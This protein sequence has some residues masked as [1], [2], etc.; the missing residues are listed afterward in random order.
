MSIR[1]VFMFGGQ[2]SQY[3]GMGRELFSAHPVFE[4]SMRALD[5]MFGDFGIPGLLHEVYPPDGGERMSFD[6]LRHTHP[7]IAMI[8][9]ALFDALAADGVEPDYLIGYSLG[10][11][12][13]ATVAGVLDRERLVAA[14]AEQVRL[15]EKNCSPGA[16]SA[17][18]GAV[19]ELYDPAER[20]WEGV[21]LAAVNHDRH[22]VVSGAPETIGRTE[23]R[24]RA[25]GITCVRLPVRYAFHSPA[26][27]AVAEP[28]LR[29]L[30]GIPLCQPR[31][32]LLSS[33]L[34]AEVT[35]PAPETL[36]RMFRGRIGFRDTVRLLEAQHDDLR[37]IDLTPSGTLARF[38][39]EN[40]RSGSGAQA[41]P[42]LDRFAPAGQ[43]LARARALRATARTRPG[44]APRPDSPHT[45]VVFPGQ[46]SHMLGMAED[47]FGEFP[48]LVAQAD[49]VLGYSV[50][51]LCVEDPDGVLGRTEFTQP[52]LF[53]ANALY[54]RAW[55]REHGPAHVFAGHSLG[56]YNALWAA[57]A[58][59][60][61]T[62]VRLVRERGA[63]MSAIAGGGMA[64]VV[65]LNESRVRAALSANGFDDLDIA[66]IN[67][68]D[69]LVISGPSTS[70]ARARETFLETGAR[71]VP[72]RVGGA[73]HS[74]YMRSARVEFER[75]L[76]GVE[77]RSPRVPVVANATARPYPDGD[78]RALL[79]EQ[80]TG[81]VRWDET[82]RH[83]LAQGVTT[84]REVGPG[85]V[86]TKLVTAIRATEPA[87]DPAAGAVPPRPS[88]SPRSTATAVAI[89]GIGCRMPGARDHREFLA[90]LRDRVDSVGE[91]PADR[92]QADLF[93]DRD[94]TAPN[95]SV[96]KWLAA[97]DDPWSFDHEYFGVSPREATLLDPL[98]RL[99]ME[100]T[101]HCLDDAG[102]T[103]A[104][105]AAAR[106]AVYIGNFERDHLI[107]M[108]HPDRDVETHS[109]L[110]VYDCLL[111]NRLSQT[112]DL[113]GASVSV[114]A[115][116]ASSLVA[117]HLG[118]QALT[119]GEADYVLAGGVNLSTRPWK[120]VGFSKA[121]MLSPDGR[122]KTFDRDANGFVPGDGVGVVLLRRYEDAV[123][124]GDHIYGLVTGTAVNHG[125]RRT[126]ITAPTVAS[127]RA[128]IAT[129]IE[130]AG[131]SPRD[132]TYVEAHGTGT[133]LGDPIEVEALRQVFAPASADTRWCALGSVKSN[134]GHLEGAAGIAGL[135]KVLMMMRARRIVPTLHV[136]TVNPLI[137]VE[138]GPFRL[139]LDEAEWR[140]TAPGEPLRAGVSSFG[141]G[142]VNSHVIV[143]EYLPDPPPKTTGDDTESATALT[144]SSPQGA[145]R[146]PYLLSAA[147]A[148]SLRRLVTSWQAALSPVGWLDASVGDICATLATGRSPLPFR[149]A[150]FAAD[151]AD[152]AEL[153]ATAQVPEHAPEARRW[154]VRV[155]TLPM[156]SP[157]EVELLLT[158]PPFREVVDEY[159]S[160]VR[161][162]L[163]HPDG[164]VARSV[165]TTIVVSALR[166]LGLRAELIAGSGP[167][168]W[169]TLAAAGCLDI[170]VAAELAAGQR[171]Q[172]ELRPPELA[173]AMPGSGRIIQPLSIDRHYLD[174]LRAAGAPDPQRFTELLAF[175]ERL[176]GQRSI[177]HTLRDWQGRLAAR[178]LGHWRVDEVTPTDAPDEP[179]RA[180]VTGI[181]VQ[182]ALDRLDRKWDLPLHRFLDGEPITEMLN[183]LLD[184]V[185][186]AEDLLGLVLDG[187][188][189]LEATAAV[190]HRNRHR[191]T[192]ADRDR[193]PML[194]RAS[195][196]PVELRDV[197]TWVRLAG[198]GQSAAIAPELSVVSVAGG[199]ATVLVEAVSADDPLTTP[200]VELWRR[201]VE[202]RWDKHPV[203]TAGKR[204][205]LPTT[206]F[207]RVEHRRTGAA[208]EATPTVPDEAR[209]IE[210]RPEW[211]VTDRIP[212][213]DSGSVLVVTSGDRAEAIRTACD[214]AYATVEFGDRFDRIGDR[215]WTVP[216]TDIEAWHRVFDAVAESDAPVRTVVLTVAGI[217]AATTALQLIKAAYGRGI[218]ILALGRHVGGAIAPELAA[219][220][221]MGRCLHRETD[222]VTLRV[223]AVPEGPADRSTWEIVAA[224]LGRADGGDL[225][226]HHHGRRE[227]RVVVPSITDLPPATESPGAGTYVVTGG[228][229][230]IGRLLAAHL[231]TRPGVRVALV[232]RAP[233]RPDL[234]DF[235]PAATDRIAYFQADIADLEAT[236]AVAAR[237]RD[238]FGPLRG[239]LHCAGTLRDGYLAHKSIDDLTAV[240]A[241]KVRGAHNLD[242]ATRDDPLDLFALFSSVV[243]VIGNP[244]Q[245][246]Y[247]TANAYLDEFAIQREALREKG[248]RNGRSISIG[249][250]IWRD[251]GMTVTEH[252]ILGTASGLRPM[253]ADTGLALWDRIRATRTGSCSFLYG[254][255]ATAVHLLPSIDRTAVR[256]AE[257]LDSAPE[258]GPSTES[259]AALARD[260]VATLIA[261]LRGVPPESIDLDLGLDR[262][263]LDSIV[264]SE[265]N[266]RIE[267]D[268]G[269][270]S[271]TLLFESRT[272]DAAAT[273]IAATR[274]AEL[275]AHYGQASNPP[276]AVE[277]RRIDATPSVASR[278]IEPENRD[279]AIVGLAGRYPMADD[280]GAF[281]ENLGAG[282]DC[283]REVPQDRPHGGDGPAAGD[284]RWGGFLDGVDAFDPLFFNISPR[285]AE[286]MDPQER[287]L[288]QTA[289]HALEDAGYPPR[290]L[291]DPDLPGGR[292]VGVF[293]G[294]TTQTYHLWGPEQRRAGTGVIPLSTQWSIANRLSYRLNL[295]GPSMPVDTACAA[296]LTA[297][298]LA[299]HSLLRGE[300]AMALVGAVNL[301]LHPAKYEWLAQLNMLS[302]TGRCHAFGA[303]ADG[304]VPGEGVGAAVLKP[305][306][307]AVADGDRIL[308]VIKG[309]AVNHGGRTSGFTVP[310]PRAQARLITD[311]LA[312]AGLAPAAIGYIEA[313]GTGTELGDP[314][315]IAGLTEAFG[316]VPPGSC[317]IGSVKSAIGH[318][319]SASG[320][321]GLTKVLLQMK[322]GRIVP[323]LHSAE[324]NPRIDF[325]ATPFTVAHDLRPW[326]RR[327]DGGVELPRRAGISSFGA[328]GS[329]A[330]VVV[331]E[332]PASTVARGPA[333]GSHLVVVS[334]SDADRLRAH[335]ANLAREIRGRAGDL[336]VS[337]IAHQLQVRREPLAERLALIADDP[338]ELADR[339]TEF[340]EDR[341]STGRNWTT[342]RDL[343][344]RE[345]AVRDLP[346]AVARRD[347]PALAA[348]WVT[349]AEV[350][351]E[352]LYPAPL[353]HVDLPGY[354]FAAERYWVPIISSAEHPFLT[355]RHDDGASVEFTGREPFL[356]HHRVD[357]VPIFPAA[358]YIEMV[359][360]AATSSG[361]VPVR[362][363]NNVWAAPI[364]VPDARTVRVAL[365]E[366][367]GHTEYTVVGTAPDGTPT[368]HATGRI[369]DLPDG[370]RPDP[371]DLAAIRA[372][373]LGEIDAVEFYS[374]IHRRGLHL[375]PT[376]Q[377]ITRVRWNGDEAIAEIHRP[378]AGDHAAY[379]LHPGMFDAA[380]QSSLWLVAQRSRDLHL[381]F[382][383][384][385]VDIFGPLPARAV[386]HVVVRKSTVTG[387][388]ID[389]R[390][391]DE[392]GRVVLRV[393]DMWLRPWPRGGSD[394]TGTYF[395]P[396]WVPSAAADR[397]E[398]GDVLVLAPTSTAAE[399]IADELNRQA[400]GP[401]RTVLATVGTSF[402]A[403]GAD[404][405]RVRPDSDVDL[406]TLCAAGPFDTVIV[407]CSGGGHTPPTAERVTEQIDADVLPV[408]LLLRALVRATGKRRIRVVC[409]YSGDS[410]AHAALGGLLRTAGRE[411]ARLSTVLVA[412]P[413]EGSD[414]TN[415]IV[416]EA[417]SVTTELEVRYRDGIRTVLRWRRT[418]HTAESASRL[419]HHGVYLI[420]GG[421]GG[422]GVLV[423]RWLAEKC[424]ARVVLAGRSAPGERFDAVAAAV[425]SAGG[426]VSYV[427]ADLSTAV[428]ARTAVEA[429]VAEYGGLHGVFHC[430]GV[431]GD[432][433]LV[434]QSAARL[435]AV[436]AGKVL[437]A[438]HLDAATADRRLD[439]LCLF[440]STAAALGSAGQAP[441]SYANGFLD[442]YAAWREARGQRT[443]SID[444]PLWAEGG[445]GVDAAVAEWLRTGLG[446][447]PLPTALGLS[448]L[449]TALDSSWTQVMF[450]P[451]DGDAVGRHLGTA[452]PPE[453]EPTPQAGQ[454]VSMSANAS[455]ITGAVRDLL[456]T[457]IADIGKLAADRIRADRPIGDYG[458]DSLSLGTLA[459]RLVK[460]L[461]VDITAA[462][463]F[464]YTT[465]DEIAAHLVDTFPAEL[466][467]TLSVTPAQAVST[468]RT[469]PGAPVVSQR[470]VPDGPEPIAII[471]MH[472]I[473]PGSP[474]LEAFWRN[475][476]DGRDL[477]T[478]I[479][480]DRWDWRTNYHTIPGPG[481]TNSKWG[482]FLPEVDRFD[483]A[484]FGISPREARLMDPQQR[485]FLQTA[486]R[487]VEE[488][489][490]RPSDLSGGRTG[491]FVG[492][493]SHDYYDLLR[494]AGVPIE[495]HTTTGLFHAILANRVSYLLD[496]TGPSFPIDT[497]C[498]SSLVA[499]RT[500]IESLR[501]G[502]CDT[503]LVGGVNLLLSPMVYLSFARAGMLS[504]TGRCRTFDTAAD[505]YVR[506]EGVGALLLKP[507]S[508]AERDGDHIHAI[509][510]GSAVNHGGK[511]STLTTPNPV[512]QADLITRA[513]TEGEVDPATVGYLELH[514]T[515]TALGDPIEINGVR[516]A[517]R[518]LRDRAGLPRLTE[519]TTLIGSVKSNMG[520]AEAAAGMAGIFKVV[521]AMKHGRIPG[522]LHISEINPH[523]EL[524]D[525]PFAIVR[526]TTAWPRMRDADG[527]ELPRRA[528]ISSFGFG[529]VNAHV[530]LEEYIP[531]PQP[532]TMPT[533]QI[534]V[535]SARS[536]E[537]LREH[538]RAVAD[539]CESA[540]AP[541]DIAYTLQ[542]GR[543]PLPHRLALVTASATELAAGLRHF[544]AT[545]A[546]GTDTWY[547]VADDRPDTVEGGDLRE[548]A[549][550]WVGGAAVDWPA[551]HTGS[552]PRR[553]SLP[554]YPFARERHW[555]PQPETEP[556]APAQPVAARRLV[557]GT[558]FTDDDEG[559]V[560]R[561]RLAT[562]DRLVDEHRVHGAAVVAGVVQLELAAAALALPRPRRVTELRW[563]RPLE[564]PE[565]G[566]EVT[567]RLTQDGG[568][569]VHEIRTERDGE[570][571]LHS[572]GRW[573]T[574]HGA[575]DVARPD[576]DAV[577]RRC[578]EEIDRLRIYRI[579]D[580]IEIEYGRLYRGL[581]T[582]WIGEGE[583]LARY[584]AD[585]GSDDRSYVFPPTV[586]D[587]ALQAITVLEA[588]GEAI[589][590]TRLPFSVESVELIA[591]PPATGYVHVL[592]G[593]DGHDI[594]VL[595][596]AGRPC[597]VLRQVVVRP[598]RD[599]L[600]GVFFRPYWTAASPS[601]TAA[602]P[603]GGWL[604]VGPPDA[605]G[606]DA[607]LTAR[608]TG[609]VWRVRTGRAN[610]R[611]AER[612]W[613]ID[614]T[615]PAEGLRDCLRE[616]GTVRH[617]W[618]LGGLLVDE[619][620]PDDPAVLGAG[621]ALLFRLVRALTET[622][623]IQHVESIR[624][625]VNDAHDVAG[626]RV[627]NP[628]AA[629]LAGLTKS[630][631]H[632]FP[633]IGVN[634]VDI[635]VPVGYRPTGAEL[636]RVVEA[637][638]DEPVRQD[639]REVALV[640]G[641][642]MV[643]VLRPVALGPAPRSAFRHG[644]NYMIIG[645]AGG[646]GLALAE[647]LAA[648]RSARLI[649]IGRSPRDR[650]IEAALERI[651][652]LGGQAAYRQA[653]V[654]NR[655]DMAAAI[656][657]AKTFGPLHGVVHAAMVLHDGI[658]ERL[659]DNAFDGVLD[660]KARGTAV[661]ADLLA[662]EPLDFLLVMSSLQTFTGAA[663]QANYAAASAAQ[664]AVAHRLATRC[665]F[666]VR[667]VN[668]GP[669]AEV[670]RVAAPDYQND[671]IAR[672]YRPLRP[673]EAIAA[674]ERILGGA[675]RQLAVLRA[676]REVLDSI[677]VVRSGAVTAARTDAT[678]DGDPAEQAA[679][680]EFVVAELRRTFAGLGI[681]TRPEEHY[682]RTSL[683]RRLGALPKYRGLIDA[684]IGIL[685]RHGVLV[686]QADL[687]VTTDAAAHRPPPEPE[688]LRARFPRLGDR[689][690][691]VSVCLAALPDVLTGARS[692]TEVLFPN[693]S[694][695]QVATLYRG[696]PQADYCNAIVAGLIADTAAAGPLRVLE[697]GAGTGATTERILDA[698]AA[699]HVEAEYDVTDVSAA[700]VR[701]AAATLAA[702]GDTARFRTLDIE[703]PALEQGFAPA[704][705]DI[706]VAANV[707]HATADLDTALGEIRRL[708]APGGRLVLT[709]VTAVQ[710]FH[711]ITFG[712]L[713]GWWRHSDTDRRLPDSPLLDTHMWRSRLED[714]G[715]ADVRVLGSGA[716]PGVLRQHVLVATVGN[717][718][719][720]DGVGLGAREVPAKS[721]PGTKMTS[722]P[723][724]RGETASA[725]RGGNA[726]DPRGGSTSGSGGGSAPGSRGRSTP[727]SGGGSTPKPGG[728]STPE[729]E[730]GNAPEPGDG[731]TP[732]S[733]SGST[734]EPG[735]GGTPGSGTGSTPE[736][737]SEST[738]GSVGKS[739]PES[740][741][742]SVPV[743]GSESTPGFRGRSAPGFGT[744]S[745]L[746]SGSGS[747]PGAGRGGASGRRGGSVG[748]AGEVGGLREGG[749][750]VGGGV[751]V[752]GERVGVRVRA[753]VTELVAACLGVRAAEVGQGTPLAELGVDSIVAVELTNRLSEALGVGLKTIVVFDHPT[754]AD[755]SA[756]IVARYG[757]RLGALVDDEPGETAVDEIPLSPTPFR[758]VRFDRPGHPRDL[759][760]VPF[761]PVAPGPGQVEV[762]VRA[763]PINF[764][765]FLFAQ[766]LYPTMP[767][768]PCTPGVEVSGVVRRVG[769]GVQRFSVGD[770]VIALTGPEFGGQ[771]S[772]VVTDEDFVVAK[773][774]NVS[775]EQACGFPVAFL[776]MYLAFERAGVRP[777]DK[778]LIP[779]A[780][781]TNGLVAVQLARLAGARV[782][783]TAGGQHKIDY[784]TRM[785]VP[786]AIDHSRADVV[787][788]VLRRT[789]GVG[790]DVVIN[791]RGGSATQEGLRV[792]AP[793]GRYVE[794]AVFGLQSSGGLDLS[795]LVDNQSFHSFNTKKFFRRHPEL[796]ARYLHTAAEYLASGEVV[797]A[798]AHVVPFDRIAEAYALKEDRALIGRVV[799][800]MPDPHTESAALAAEEPRTPGEIPVRDTDIAVIG[801]SGRFPGAPDV[802]AFWDN[803]ASG[804]S[805]IREVP[806]ER[807]RSETY[808]DP[809]PRRLDTSNCKWGG[810]LDDV[811]RFDATFF[812]ISA[813]EAA[814]TDPQQ[815]LFLEE[816]W[817][818]VED[819]GYPTA[820][821]RG[822][823]CGVFV[824]V[825][826]SQYLS[827]MTAAG[828]PKPAQVFWGNESS[829]LAGRIAYL[830]DLKGPTMAVNTACSSSLVA[831][832]L[833]VQSLIRGEC[834]TAIAGGVFVTVDP[835]YYVVA[836]NGGM[837]AADGRCKTF[838]AAADGFVPG[839]AVAALVLKP[840]AAALRDGDRIHGVV[841]GSAV[842]QD[843]RTNGLTAPSGTAQTEVA[844]AAYAA[845][846]I[847]PATIGYVEAH[848]TGTGLGDAIEVEALTTAFRTRTDR[849][850][851]CAIGTAKTNVGHTAAASGMVGLIK[852]LLAMR[853]RQIPPSLNFDNPN[854]MIDFESS[855]FVVN[856][857]L[858][859]WVPQPG[860]PRRAAV[861]GFGFSGTNAHVLLE[862][863]PRPSLSAFEPMA[864]PVVVPISAHTPGALRARC[865]QLA[866]W[867]D[868]PGTQTPMADLA[869]HLQTRRDHFA[870]RAVFV[871]ADRTA[872]R[873]AL[874]H[875]DTASADAAVRNETAAAYLSGAEVTWANNWHGRSG[876][877]LTLPGYPFEPQ[878]HWFTN[879]DRV[880][881][882]VTADNQVVGPVPVTTPPSIPE[883]HNLFRGSGQPADESEVY[884]IAMTTAID[885]I[886]EVT[887]GQSC[888]LEPDTSHKDHGVDSVRAMQIATRINAEL[889][890]ALRPTDLFR[891]PTLRLLAA[892]IADL[893]GAVSVA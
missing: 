500:A 457:E 287:L 579:F 121:R 392:S 725:P 299:V 265:F 245:G 344:A 261:R 614:P 47:L 740:G 227:T 701:Q 830:L 659:S 243:A 793:E 611:T 236:V 887:G 102:V 238:R 356:D 315:E 552:H 682:T 310:N 361:G 601:A 18:L 126:T 237:I 620:A 747:T 169:P 539:H 670:G 750:V 610:R 76:N 61:G 403:T 343:A 868:G 861:S 498:S 15:V 58:F 680:D 440:S 806:G 479:P 735:T 661:L 109:V 622:D 289:W 587:A 702:A 437:G 357:G 162:L 122:C 338:I 534:F 619:T 878:R 771:A 798:V 12:V 885:A 753:V 776:A 842:N 567:I 194:W 67:S 710:P 99:L 804:T 425:R 520:H 365:A 446:L 721:T 412:L 715:F 872:L 33:A 640:G 101:Q 641:R 857:R 53:V 775:H 781:G 215:G 716:T 405:Y 77:L 588:A 741:I 564:V 339:L 240:L 336:R 321:A 427:Q 467:E 691:L 255:P 205:P 21:E 390:V 531:E 283:I 800:T 727:E 55:E 784:L 607:A 843:G 728:G 436:V 612:V 360:A 340:A 805:S 707:L 98:Q 44:P 631:A 379:V 468:P 666:P 589:T 319:E 484:F 718:E 430:A 463:F 770:E 159:G 257:I 855:P 184:G 420:S 413:R 149:I 170:T 8:Q 329:N 483:A 510:R 411:S 590:T 720:Q 209:L 424:G 634:C 452:E 826:P 652:Q 282:R 273:R 789:D 858:R 409:G 254:D 302:P 815:R 79:A 603:E 847:D 146:L 277:E 492:V 705:Y 417:L 316:D 375:G 501:A 395:R 128:V 442:A 224:E 797:P 292:A 249:W 810:F 48:D 817:R 40:L 613:E 139:A 353:P 667:I 605:W 306:R 41:I 799:V 56:E 732:G 653:D 831:L 625:V 824:G 472:G 131:I 298:H 69:Q 594:L 285:E 637:L 23:E 791:T 671:L 762:Q 763:F 822:S 545:G 757:D 331:E 153:L 665:G 68:A 363:R 251:G 833:A 218:S 210:L 291:G 505:G 228:L 235:G 112:F 814:Y 711:T 70:L 683:S 96:S 835:D 755:L 185:L 679:L 9:L 852:V 743:S 480:P 521:L 258:S 617:I 699:G 80:L 88:R 152:I 167:G 502:S 332:A 106:T 113:S 655:D 881:G 330:H 127:E 422:L 111:A 856:T 782:V 233:Q 221:G 624:S 886:T 189:G 104:T 335:C 786:D 63:L 118:V 325:A 406:E 414:E 423:A 348:A 187:D 11:S 263:G 644:G 580:A 693:G 443:I 632:E 223:L 161:A 81:P 3:Y 203:A 276:T 323:S 333:D 397:R 475:L 171:P 724:T 384:G 445:M 75:F 849:T 156:P 389:V 293:A 809:D 309:T 115:A 536:P 485:L 646:I 426:A 428:G 834:E 548:L 459:N 147:S 491:L 828:A 29:L 204:V 166:W 407:E 242:L 752:D 350:P 201:G 129:A 219:L 890:I 882:A 487:A 143:E 533:E 527:T 733:G 709:E 768:F 574:G 802:D 247:A 627:G 748:G 738:P 509:V 687:L 787:S 347:L 586:L 749:G 649:L 871:V 157:G 758:A 372:R 844:L 772:V 25:R 359:R 714:A 519:P 689:L 74:R 674:L 16:M 686:E 305:L 190:A 823:R 785:G 558:G 45:A 441:Y 638:L 575:A 24:L 93:Y 668:W 369:A 788:E 745:A 107:D 892:H 400:G 818:A 148:A 351:W 695:A 197:D 320:L 259:A 583:L 870:H 591:D 478:E 54:Y 657:K 418:P 182:Y 560:F 295:N 681:F 645:G 328:G 688:A 404:R 250:P 213:T 840:L 281:W 503:A 37:Y 568:D 599:V 708:L 592:R 719:M 504:P 367:A 694:M 394:D 675:E 458:F 456:V 2:G 60:F 744:G 769:P 97:L 853:H 685:V 304:F 827:R 373:C 314:I 615:D 525:S 6:T 62:G 474:D 544:A 447:H 569:I 5:T 370:D 706:V 577:R 193:Y 628:M 606:L 318:L 795:R 865:A 119:G 839:E 540:G 697:V 598:E 761:D 133:A 345:R 547:A 179:R 559:V 275:A 739:T 557:D 700:L 374:E 217:D 31:I 866:R 854:P 142:G 651:D 867:L 322:H 801:M 535:L 572:T 530:L 225:I 108:T 337:E 494:D 341:P 110:G 648:T 262:L 92:W 124:D 280:L 211:R 38:A 354:P 181:A 884:R 297:V 723:G 602:S 368:T 846:D 759:R 191:I 825:G 229:G 522:N 252:G 647:H 303:D 377:G 388:K 581:R 618:F 207:D 268:L 515:G 663:G 64:A 42:L 453:P 455:D 410:P 22:F 669:W 177:R 198:T 192:P 35:D 621:A 690:D 803:L 312:A 662:A 796:R 364:A 1:N 562:S 497:A 812:G 145:P 222:S 163:D 274:P 94:I 199:A 877:P 408:L 470:R 712:L 174:R 636:E 811:S 841:K 731:S 837:L 773:P 376:Y 863:P 553:V 730:G 231:L 448:A 692:A 72:L 105:L 532:R 454:E 780:T 415:H 464:E 432:D 46:G 114:D 342:V 434:R 34:V 883:A 704:H 551:L 85:N 460:R 383:I 639:G 816:A 566:R 516:R 469:A 584:T 290:R 95:R 294:V 86:L 794:I 103:A 571:I 385:S 482:G 511:V 529:G 421:A 696:E 891:F 51:K 850:G 435:R 756:Y 352:S 496:L 609:P 508:A 729:P 66:N 246:D 444:W 50:R 28:Y 507:L 449:G 726:P 650:R 346:D 465:V 717:V 140:P 366:V 600:D 766:G 537:Q 65:G 506:A 391:A 461:T 49:D 821:V 893:L 550:H 271:E 495:A 155:G 313:H 387:T 554:T 518:Q 230:R 642:R 82:V 402:E 308:G 150:G 358:G 673:A 774:D 206:E 214:D 52:A 175:A 736:S 91:I 433:Y 431:L 874:E 792:L 160:R 524:N 272:L 326:P 488:A 256:P 462:L 751:A 838:D 517:F 819:T 764:S 777:G 30:S 473:L 138:N 471:G 186:E 220:A 864:G 135:I 466:A 476:D 158:L 300:C 83:L 269:P 173:V 172:A 573:T 168:I 880:F 783:A 241:P 713:D 39:T 137:D 862:E 523:I 439:F 266:A 813:E 196:L 561:V 538:A 401:V 565:P 608:H 672:G 677:G 879:D 526:R 212:S 767:D 416:R 635:G 381:P 684:V 144:L 267:A 543:E 116:C 873:A 27:D 438:V 386:S 555:I 208:V 355:T 734:P 317:A 450:V 859:E 549:R 633:R 845:A 380:L 576:I 176:G 195:A 722:A 216:P 90:N 486:Y 232:G 512:A 311:A 164:R 239:V 546:P 746:E 398:P 585:S 14:V 100:E 419:R 489:G 703:R 178:G 765:D 32:R 362:L 89:V 180:L 286:T 778:V 429:A 698:L 165:F 19:G 260:Y 73:F 829:V 578:V 151:R 848:G 371:L 248:I 869:Y 13:A 875:P 288:L 542:L 324:P 596:D 244:G 296:A 678:F 790:V 301:Y 17:I 643:R 820:A 20:H 4:R 616:I 202:V 284:Y 278:G 563:L 490:Y 595:D 87:V 7:A 399:R 59:D 493:A 807:W 889:G 664:D 132:I 71:Y 760:V 876:P 556:I 134:I 528:G 737:D 279:I 808:Y 26:V 117:V 253:S 860:S 604:V 541:A 43:G 36:W 382:S 754:V 327:H 234:S 623:L 130:R 656:A 513:L 658:V 136:R 393:T 264:V 851:F 832:H 597:V 57:G 626:R 629:A 188:S 270:V 593:P 226:R 836:G 78:I 378:E 200:S 514:G 84:I 123:R 451:G 742:K 477:V 183:L 10:E 396:D 779:A 660:P 570:S 141:F 120:Y 888:T 154:A 307:A 125:R 349:G 630:L 582:A 499:L 676:E 481:R 654:T 334:A